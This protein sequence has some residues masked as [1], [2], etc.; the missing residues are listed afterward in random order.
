VGIAGYTLY[1]NASPIIT[2][3]STFYDDANLS[4]NTLYSYTIL[5]RDPSG[6]T[7][8]QSQQVTTITLSPITKHF[9]TSQMLAIA[10]IIYIYT[11][12][13]NLAIAYSSMLTWIGLSK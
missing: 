13:N 10:N 6:N 9:K 11:S 4:P 2:V 7:S 5:A 8:S 12:K 3:T 1:R